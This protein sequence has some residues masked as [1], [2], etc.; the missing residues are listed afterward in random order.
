MHVAQIT[1]SRMSGSDCLAISLYL[2]QYEFWYAT[3][4]IPVSFWPRRLADPICHVCVLVVTLL[5]LKLIW[6]HSAQILMT[7]D[8][9]W[10]VEWLIRPPNIT[11][12][13]HSEVRRVSHNLWKCQR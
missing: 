1:G 3:S 13:S 2:K 11:L 9:M 7:G 5:D 12:E 8:G 6:A 4:V 10:L